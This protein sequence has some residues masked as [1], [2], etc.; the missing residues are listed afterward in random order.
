MYARRSPPTELHE[1]HPWEGHW[2]TW[3]MLYFKKYLIKND[4]HK[5][6]HKKGHN[7]I[8]CKPQLKEVTRLQKYQIVEL[9]YYCTCKMQ[10]PIQVMINEW[11]IYT[12][13]SVKESCIVQ[14]VHTFLCHIKH[15]EVH[16]KPETMTQKDITAALQCALNMYHNIDLKRVKFTAS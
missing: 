2:F 16:C 13:S 14:L 1:L 11:K 7:Q 8:F 10:V 5:I 15:M 12:S 3:K 9:V 4:L 6:K